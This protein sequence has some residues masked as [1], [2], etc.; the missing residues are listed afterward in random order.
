MPTTGP[1]P[2]T[3]DYQG[4]AVELFAKQRYTAEK[5]SHGVR[6]GFVR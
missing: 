3:V 1:V 6:H 2:G 4:V 5:Q